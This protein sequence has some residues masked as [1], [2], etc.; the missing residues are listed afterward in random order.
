MKR[1]FATIQQ[2]SVYKP[3]PDDT[4]LPLAINYQG[5]LL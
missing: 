3:G 4:N 5:H 2:T 1:A